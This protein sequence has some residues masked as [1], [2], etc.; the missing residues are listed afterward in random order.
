MRVVTFLL[1][2]RLPPHSQGAVGDPGTCL[3]GFLWMPEIICL[4]SFHLLLP[5]SCFQQRQAQG[6]AHPSSMGPQLCLCEPEHVDVHSWRKA[7]ALMVE[8][9][10]G[11]EGGREFLKVDK[12]TVEFLLF[13]FLF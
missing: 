10:M 6:I 2:G 5:C 8:E 1:W 9:K 4:C 12:L 13:I 3:S 11:P 7:A